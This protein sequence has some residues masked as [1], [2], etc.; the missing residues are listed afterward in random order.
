MP[1]VGMTLRDSLCSPD[2]PR[3]CCIEQAFKLTEMYLPLPA[4]YWD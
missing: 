4:Q 2:W 3:T 1:K